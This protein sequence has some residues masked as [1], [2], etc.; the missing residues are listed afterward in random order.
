MKWMKAGNMAHEY[1]PDFST[2]VASISF[3]HLTQVVKVCE[4]GV[5]VYIY[6][7]IYDMYLSRIV[8]L[9]ARENITG[10][11]RMDDIFAPLGCP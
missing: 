6:I 7:R 9:L 2:I 5:C 3:H 10:F 4:L 8:S 1:H 11:S